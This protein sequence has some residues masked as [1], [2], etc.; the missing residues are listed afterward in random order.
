MFTEERAM[1]DQIDKEMV[2]LFEERMNVVTSVAH[3]KEAAGLP[4]LDSSR[5]QQVLE[6]VVSYLQNEAYSPYLREFY[7]ALMATSRQYQADHIKK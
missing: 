7:T 2:A 1:I 5:E 6:K 3:K 4:I